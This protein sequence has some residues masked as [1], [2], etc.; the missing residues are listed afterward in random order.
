MLP[1]WPR[2]IL[3]AS[4]SRNCVVHHP[5]EA[6]LQ[7]ADVALAQRVDLDAVEGEQL[8]QLRGV[9]EIARQAIERLGQH[10]VEAASAASAISAW[11]PGRSMVAPEIAASV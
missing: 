6:D 2:R 9:A 10:D 7:L 8:V 3:R 4:S 11:M 5:L 1:R